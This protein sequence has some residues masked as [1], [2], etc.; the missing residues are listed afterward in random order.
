MRKQLL[1]GFGAWLFIMSAVIVALLVWGSGLSSITRSIGQPEDDELN[2]SIVRVEDSIGWKLVSPS[3]DA[4]GHDARISYKFV[5][6]N[7]TIEDIVVDAYDLNIRFFDADGFALEHS[8]YSDEF[9]VPANSDYTYS[10]PYTLRR[11][12]GEQVAYI[13]VLGVRSP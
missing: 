13:E 2:A 11:G 7:P 12:L 8:F 6:R 3:N 5:V 1:L 4:F 10:S 9:T